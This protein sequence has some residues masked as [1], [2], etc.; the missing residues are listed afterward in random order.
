MD[1]DILFLM[2]HHHSH[3]PSFS[4]RAGNEKGKALS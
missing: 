3:N 1:V 2:A 4:Q